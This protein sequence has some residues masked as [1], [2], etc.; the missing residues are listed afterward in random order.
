LRRDLY[1]AIGGHEAV[2]GEVV[3]D[4]ALARAAKRAGHLLPWARGE[5]VFSLRYQKGARGVW[6]G[7]RKNAAHAWRGPWPVALAAGAAVMTLVL[8]PW[9]ALLRGKRAAGLAGVLLQAA[10]LRVSAGATDVG[11]A[12]ALAA[13]AA[14]AFMSA[15]GL[16]SLV[17]RVSGRGARWRG[18]RIPPAGVTRGSSG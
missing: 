18:R 3:E 12:Y 4:L 5:A 10:T 8:A 16:A 11:A 14:A 2:R 1:A 9:A 7:W 15:V 17:D 13:P 6:H